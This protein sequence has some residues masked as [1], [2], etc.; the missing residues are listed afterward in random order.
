MKPSPLLRCRFCQEDH[1]A[2]HFDNLGQEQ[3]CRDCWEFM[4]RCNCR[5]ENGKLVHIWTTIK[6]KG[7]SYRTCFNF[8]D[9]ET[10]FFDD[11]AARK[12]WV[13]TVKKLL[14]LGEK[15]MHHIERQ[16]SLWL[17]FS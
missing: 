15:S 16:L 8:Q 11:D 2:C 6:A 4:D 9:E 12:P 10:I 7:R 14:P 13:L 1:P 5:R 17:T 3:M